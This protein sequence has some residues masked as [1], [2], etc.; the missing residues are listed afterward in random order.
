MLGDLV[1]RRGA[2]GPEGYFGRHIARKNRQARLGH[3]GHALDP[4]NVDIIVRMFWRR[5]TVYAFVNVDTNQ[6]YR[7]DWH[8]DLRSQ[9]PRCTGG[10]TVSWPGEAGRVTVT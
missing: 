4:P 6:L 7:S 5:L 1:P 10:L 9:R 2:G 3:L 8:L